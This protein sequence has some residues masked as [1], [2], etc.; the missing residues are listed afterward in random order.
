MAAAKGRLKRDDI[1]RFFDYGLDVA[2]RTIMLVGDIE[3]YSVDQALMALHI[4]SQSP[5]D[6]T[7]R[8]ATNGGCWYSGMALYDAICAGENHIRIIGTGNV[9]S[10]G[11]IILQAADERILT[12]NATLLVHYGSDWAGGHVKDLERRAMENKR[13]GVVMEDLFLDRIRVK[14]PEFTREQFKQKFSFDVYMSAQEAIDFGLA[15]EI[16]A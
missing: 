1:D 16:L 4:L 8:L 5:G 14:H 11:G 12:P 3:E 13:T 9:M 7:I 10:M 6:I 15:D 2:S